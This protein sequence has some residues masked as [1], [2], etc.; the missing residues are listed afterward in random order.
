[1]E[2]KLAPWLLLTYCTFEIPVQVSP[3]CSTEGTQK[4]ELRVKVEPLWRPAGV[5]VPVGTRDCGAT[6]TGKCRG[7]SIA[8]SWTC[9]S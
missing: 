3:Q 8:G 7:S 4:M 6:E 1:M 5:R 9:Y 2:F